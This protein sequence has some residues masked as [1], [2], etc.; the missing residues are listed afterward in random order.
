MSKI[1]LE[2]HFNAKIELYHVKQ[3]ASFNILLCCLFFLYVIA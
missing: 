1:I 2:K 3:R